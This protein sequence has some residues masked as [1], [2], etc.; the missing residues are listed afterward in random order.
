MVADRDSDCSAVAS[1]SAVTV[2]T[3]MVLSGVC[4][5]HLLTAC[6]IAGLLLQALPSH[7]ECLSL[8][9]LKRLC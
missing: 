2:L 1:G 9:V 8:S 4:L 7:V 5:R 3:G 6:L